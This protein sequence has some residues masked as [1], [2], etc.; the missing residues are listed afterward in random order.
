MSLP[1][2]FS[3]GNFP[4]GFC[5]Q[6]PQQYAAALIAILT[7][8]V[9]ASGK[10][11]V[12]AS[13]P[14]PSDRD[15]VWFRTVGGYLEGIYTFLGVWARPHPVPASSASRIIWTDTEANAWAYDSGDGTDPGSIAPT[16]TTGAMWQVDHG[17]DF[18]I[19]MGAGTNSTTYDSQPATS[20]AQGSTAGAEKVALADKETP[21][22]DHNLVASPPAA[23]GYIIMTSNAGGDWGYTGAAH[24]DI[25]KTFSSFG[26]DPVDFHTWAHSNLP[27]VK[28]V[29][30]LKRTSRLYITAS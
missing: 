25:Y 28:G 18:T 27:P 16:A 29:F 30:F 6:N 11:I 12:S 7:G 17:M 2:S 3:L 5:W 22:H 21:Y 24:T 26:G 10:V 4:E 13:A 9:N 23:T 15:A 19:P 20:L 14:G 1:V 8:T